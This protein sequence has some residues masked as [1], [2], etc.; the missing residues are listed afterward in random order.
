M[1]DMEVTLIDHMGS[2]LSVVNAARVSLSKESHW[3]DYEPNQ[4]LPTDETLLLFLARGMSGN[5]YERLCV[6]VMAEDDVKKLKRIMNQWRRTP[7]HWSPFAHTGLSF[8]VKAPI[9]VARQ[10]QKSTVGFS[11]NEV[12]RRYVKSQPEMYRMDTWRKQAADVKQGSSE[13]PVDPVLRQR[14]Y[15][16]QTVQQAVDTLENYAKDL[17][18]ELIEH[19]VCAEQARSILPQSAM[20]EWIWTGSLYAFARMCI[21]R[22]DSHT[23]YET[24]IIAKEIAGHLNTLFPKSWAALSEGLYEQV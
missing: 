10:L 18:E 6:N 13:V 5:D 23:Q 19:G 1:A 16:Q 15:G 7:E 17:Y 11:W 22:L 8:R 2:D 24:R 12:S 9:F 4:L 20:T 14:M 3:E 21:L